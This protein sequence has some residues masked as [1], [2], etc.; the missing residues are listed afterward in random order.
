MLRRSFLQLMGAAP[1]AAPVIAREAAAKAGVA[2]MD[3]P[4]FD[5]VGAASIGVITAGHA[6]VF[7]VF[8]ALCVASAAACLRLLCVRDLLGR[9]TS[10]T[11]MRA[12]AGGVL[13]QVLSAEP[14]RAG[15]AQ[16]FLEQ[17]LRERWYRAAERSGR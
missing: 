14:A 4:H 16:H 1:I 10:L 6:C 5:E 17:P 7:R 13:G 2:A 12:T 15:R 9:A 3:Y 11:T 8:C